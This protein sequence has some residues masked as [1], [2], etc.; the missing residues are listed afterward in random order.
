[1]VFTYHVVHLLYMMGLN[2]LIYNGITLFTKT[3]MDDRIKKEKQY[4]SIF[5]FIIIVHSN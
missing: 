3:M 2:V 5:Y 4:F 1:M